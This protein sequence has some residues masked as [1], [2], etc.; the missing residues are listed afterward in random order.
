MTEAILSIAN[1]KLKV[2]EENNELPPAVINELKEKLEETEVTKEEL[3]Q[4]IE[5]ARKAYSQALVEPGEA[6]GT[7]AAQSIGEPGTQM[8]IPGDERVIIRNGTFSDIV[9]IGDF[10]DDLIA[11]YTSFETT[12]NPLKSTV[13]DLPA[14]IEMYVPALGSDEHI[15]WRKLRQVSRHLSNGELIKI[16]TRSGRTI[17]TTLS[18]SFVIRKDNTIIPIK[19]KNLTVG[20]R[21]PLTCSLQSDKPLKNI[22]LDLYLPR[23]EVWYGS[24]LI[25]AYKSI[26]ELGSAWKKE[27]GVA[28][29]VPVG[30]DGLRVAIKTNKTDT[31]MP[32]FVYPKNYSN[33]DIRVPETLELNFLFGWF[34]GAYLAEG[35]NTGTFIS[36]ANVDEIYRERVINFADNF[37]VNYH[38][39]E[40][41]GQYG[42]SISI[43]IHSSLLAKLFKEMCGKGANNKHVPS[44][45]LNTPK[46]FVSG[47]LRGYFDGDGNVSLERS[48]IRSSSNSKNLR[49]AICLLLS[50]LGIYASK[51]KE[52][53]QFWLRIPGKYAKRYL[54]LIGSDVSHKRESLEKM[55]KIE[56]DK[57]QKE[58]LTYD[59][60][61]MIPGFGMT[62]KEIYSKLKIPSKS[63]FA[64]TIR[65]FTKKQLIG[66]RTLKRYIERFRR[67]AEKQ[68]INIDEQLAILQRAYD[69]DVIWDEIVKLELISSPTEYVYDFAVDDLETFIT[70]E[71]LVTHNTLRTFHYAG[72]AELNVT[73]GLPRL[74]EIVDA[75]KNPSTPTMTVYL[76][77]VNKADGVKA[78]EVARLI[79]ETKIE[80]VTYDIEIN[81]SNMQIELKLDPDLM[82]DKGLTAEFI[83]E[84]LKKLK[85]GDAELLDEYTVIVRPTSDSFID[86]QKLA[87]KI[88]TLPLKGLKDVKR[89]VIRKEED[90]FVIYSEGTNLLNVLRVPGVDPMR[91]FS[92]HI[93]EISECLG[94]EAARNII[95]SEAI[96]VLEEQGLDVDLRHVMLV[97]DLMTVTGEVRQIGRHGIS[98]EKASVL[99]RAAFE[100]TVKHLLE[101]STRGEIDHLKGITENVIIGQT[102]LLGTGAIDLMMS[103]ERKPKTK[104]DKK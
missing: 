78:R 29:T 87:E 36:I 30:I 24:E 68:H 31:L 20:D 5:E 91:T 7:I 26:E 86:L 92:N 93:H 19:G 88:R 94:I 47:L 67:L 44:W 4:I 98:G 69:S 89:T 103:R 54:D 25:N 23:D 97:A 51:Y 49:D 59:I 73:L 77:D 38:I 84:K 41:E 65:K 52:G 57:E 79:E 39:G 50:R 101:A 43:S 80:K 10:V 100:V 42:P 34:V 35:T 83:V 22:P 11:Q 46:R 95:I 48:Q 40:S 81:L 66:R 21:I 72:V 62:L 56:I 13:C 9:A 58:K 60:I 74:I 17:T 15:H 76:D 18:H 99:A 14:H 71:G 32:G 2:L 96:T 102:I 75:R 82:E 70:A 64:A 16:T 28:Y 6:V 45:V 90:E 37:G 1:K 85:K 53:N 33:K 8:S 3:D 27:Y 12:Y 61:D 55:A 104:E 63:S